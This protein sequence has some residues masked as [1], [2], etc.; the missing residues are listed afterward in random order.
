M[1]PQNFVGWAKIRYCAYP[2]HTEIQPLRAAAVASSNV[3]DN[4]SMCRLPRVDSARP[5][6]R[7]IGLHA[8]SNHFA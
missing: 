5:D 1:G 7:D 3:E 6:I 8:I 4:W 2:Q